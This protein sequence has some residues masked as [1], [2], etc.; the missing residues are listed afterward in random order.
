M[1]WQKNFWNIIEL[2]KTKMLDLVM[3]DRTVFVKR[4]IYEKSNNG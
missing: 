1:V 2:L 3:D 4:G